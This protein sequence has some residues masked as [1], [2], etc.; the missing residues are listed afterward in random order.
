MASS[1]LIKWFD[2]LFS[3]PSSLL[4]SSS[5][6]ASS[7]LFEETLALRL[8][9]LLPVPCESPGTPI[10]WLASALRV[11]S[12]TLSDAAAA[13]VASDS[14]DSDVD[15]LDSSVALLDACN[16]VS[17][18]IA[19]VERRLLYLR[20]AL[21]CL[22][23]D[24]DGHDED[25]PKGKLHCARKAVAEWESIPSREI[26]RSAGELIHRMA[27]RCAE[28][29]ARRRV[30]YAAEEVSR[31]VMAAALVALGGREGKSQI[32]EMRVSCDCPWAEAFNQV[33]AA[34]SDRL[35]ASLPL[36]LA[37]VEAEVGTLA[38]GIEREDVGDGVVAT[39]GRAAE[40]LTSALEKLRESVNGAFQAATGTRNAL[41][42]GL[43]ARNWS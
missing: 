11:L 7:R 38:R 4:E 31:L 37:T 9:S 8:R 19:R 34:V 10:L 40:E 27:P 2:S 39:V 20:L 5:S 6:S 36:E 23:P 14:L 16:A 43:R 15:Y 22:T 18:E 26:G 35:G 28:S 21:R 33:A 25:R 17:A 12:L 41:L 13:F 32:G 1:G 30:T 24:E 29:A 42:N 3:H